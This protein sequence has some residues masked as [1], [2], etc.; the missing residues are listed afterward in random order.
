MRNYLI[1]EIQGHAAYTVDAGGNLLVRKQGKQRAKKRVMLAAHMDEVGLIVSYITE[2]GYLKFAAVGGLETA[3]L[4]GKAVLVGDN[5]V[6]GVIGV[7]PIHFLDQAERA[8]LPERES[9][10]ID[11]GVSN[12]EQALENVQPGDM[13]TFDSQFT[14]LGGEAIK[15]RALDDRAGC[16]VLLELIQSE[17]PYDLDFAFTVQEEVGTVGAKTAAFSLEPD[18]AFVVETTTAADLPGVEGEKRVCEIGKGAVLSFMDKGTVYDRALYRHALQLARER[19]IQV[20]SKTLVAG[21]NDA[22]AIHKSRA[23]VRTIAVSYPCRYLHS[24]SC[25]IDQSDMNPVYALVAALAE[26]CANGSLD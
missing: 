11:I 15:A 1:A 8:K 26:E 18:Y 3:V 24:P 21:G 13:V 23:G 12:R 4:P 16:A 2:E 7:K 17:L 20:Q 14:L 9:L 6:P 22:A 19:G 5:A 10:Y 25:V